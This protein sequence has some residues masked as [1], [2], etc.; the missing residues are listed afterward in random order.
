MQE[1]CEEVFYVL[2]LDGGMAKQALYGQ[3]NTEDL[4]AEIDSFSV[5]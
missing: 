2:M 3:E 1:Q 4:P 5:E